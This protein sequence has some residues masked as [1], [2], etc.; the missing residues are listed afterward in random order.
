MQFRGVPYVRCLCQILALCIRTGWCRLEI[1]I[2]HPSVYKNWG[3]CSLEINRP[4]VS[5]LRLV[6]FRSKIHQPSVSELGL[7]QFR[8]EIN[9]PSVS[10]LRLVQFR[11]EINPPSVSEL[12]L[13]QFRD[14]SAICVGTEAGAV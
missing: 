1:L 9:Q 14:K 2:S 10:E 8:S 6:Q 4:S 12:A 13:V 11:S 3:W 5:E 7:V